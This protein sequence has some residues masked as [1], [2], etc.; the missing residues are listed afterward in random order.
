MNILAASGWVE[1]A[2]AVIHLITDDNLRAVDVLRDRNYAPQERSVVTVE[3]P[4]TPGILRDLTEMIG[5]EDLD[6]HHVYTGAASDGQC[7]LVVSTSN[8]DRAFVLLND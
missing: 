5:Q 1:G 2:D 8:N 4:H 7:L 6:I 3:A